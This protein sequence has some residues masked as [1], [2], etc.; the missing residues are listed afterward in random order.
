MSSHIIEI[1]MAKPSKSS[2]RELQI[3][4]FAKR[5]AGRTYIAAA[6]AAKERL[7]SLRREYLDVP[8][9]YRGYIMVG[10]CTCLES[11][12]K[13]CYA[14]AAER[15]AD[16]PDVLKQLYKDIS[17]DIDTLI[18]TSAR[19]FHLSDV[20]AA[21]IKVSSLDTYLRLS[22]AFFTAIEG[23]QHDFPWDLSKVFGFGDDEGG[24]KCQAEQLDRL[25]NVFVVRHDFVHEAFTEPASGLVDPRE[26]VDDAI[27]LITLFNKNLEYIEMSPKF[28]A[29]NHDEGLPGAVDRHVE[30][31]D[32]AFEHIKSFCE[33]RQ[34]EKLEIFRQAFLGYLWAR[35]EFQASVFL[36]F[37]SE[38]AASEFLDLVSK[39][40]VTLNEIALKQK[41]LIA[42]FPLA[43]QYEE[44][45]VEFDRGNS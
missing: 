16:Y 43:K 40:R 9:A 15:F 25:R 7:L 44:M 4:A 35:C 1:G 37:A 21:N 2:T 23:R 26:Y 36:S 13:Y 27:Q 30:N 45:G 12:L 20:I 22:S 34:Y 10:I 18:S 8:S 31:I 5:R 24:K 3:E 38:S 6:S 14:Y 29:I 28:S 42:E 39:Y 19:S 11:H 41:H 33:P 32:S 17:V